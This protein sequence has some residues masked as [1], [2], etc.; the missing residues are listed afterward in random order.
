M[1]YS[2]VFHRAG[3]SAVLVEFG[4]TMDPISNAH[5]VSYADQVRNA[6]WPAVENVILG[7]ASVLVEF[8]PARL[9]LATLV[10]RLQAVAGPLKS[11]PRRVWEIPVWYGGVWGPDL[12]WVAERLG[13]D[14]DTVIALHVSPRYQIY[15]L[16][17]TPGFPFCGVLPESLQL[18][19]RS[20]PRASV[21]AGSVAIAGS[22]TG[23]Y[24]SESPGGWHLIGRTP[25]RLFQWQEQQPVVYRAGDYIQFVRM[26]G[27]EEF[28]Q[29]LGRD[30]WPRL[31][32][33]LP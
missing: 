26:D 27:V 32:E 4:T 2:P 33:E 20:A 18:P 12:L 14:P 17:F 31:L 9:A 3:D 22:Q 6:H 30:Q 8:D 7:Y 28:D 11:E 15:G 25:V 13:L 16:G 5:A 24:P 21:P 29:F 19:R 23:I 1:S 10:K